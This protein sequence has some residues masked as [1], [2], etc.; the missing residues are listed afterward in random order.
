MQFPFPQLPD[1]IDEEVILSAISVEKDVD[2]FHPINIGK[3]GMRGRD[4]LFT[5]CTPKARKGVWSHTCMYK[6]KGL[7]VWFGTGFLRR[8]TPPTYLPL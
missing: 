5:P 8:T 4:A 1:H 3:L 2:G 7:T 6:K